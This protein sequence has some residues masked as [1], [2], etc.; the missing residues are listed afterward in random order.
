MQSTQQPLSPEISEVLALQALSWLARTPETAIPFLGASGLAAS[1]I[2]D[3]ASDPEFLGFVLDYL[4]AD[5]ALLL[6]FC[7]ET[8]TR[9]DRPQRARAGLPGGDQTHWT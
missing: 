1:D 8:N 2:S 4:L 3:R 9:P 5:E 6:K 7:E